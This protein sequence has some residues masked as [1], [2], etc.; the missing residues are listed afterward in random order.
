MVLFTDAHRHADE[1]EARVALVHH[2][3]PVVVVLP[4]DLAVHDGLG[5]SAVASFRRH[6]KS[7]MSS[8]VR[9]SPEAQ[10]DTWRVLCTAA[11]FA[12]LVFKCTPRQKQYGM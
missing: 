7:I 9:I 1:P 6:S 5:V 8:S 10:A 11:P 3:A 12:Q 4:V 2:A